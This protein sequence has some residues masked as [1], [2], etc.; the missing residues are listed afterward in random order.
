VSTP[1][2]HPAENRTYRELYAMSRQLIEHWKA[3]AGRLPASPA[4]DALEQGYAAVRRMLH[5]L[6]PLTE[7]YGLHGKPAAQGVG[8]RLATARTHLRDRAMERGQALRAAVLDIQHLTTTLLFLA[9][10][11]DSRGDERMAGF[12]RKWERS[13]RRTENAVRKAVAETGSDPDDAVEPLDDSPAGRAAHGAA[14]AFG[15]LGEWL[16]KQRGERG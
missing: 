8:A 15:T 7:T 12:C 10:V 13:L 11:A 4:T 1:S 3:L 16:D 2:L 9:E 14:Y 6:G 5:E